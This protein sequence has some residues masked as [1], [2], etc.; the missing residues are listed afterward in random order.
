MI[1]KKKKS[2]RQ[3]HL[4]HLPSWTYLTKLVPINWEF[5]TA[6]NIS[7]KHTRKHDSLTFTHTH[8]HTHA[9]T[10]I[11]KNIVNIRSYSEQ[12][13]ILWT[14]K[15]KKSTH[16]NLHTWLVFTGTYTHIV[17]KQTKEINTYIL[18]APNNCSMNIHRILILW[19]HTSLINTH[20][21]I[22]TNIHTNTLTHTN[23]YAHT[24]FVSGFVP[25]RVVTSTFTSS[26]PT[27]KLFY[28]TSTHFCPGT[29][30]VCMY[31]YLC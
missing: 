12:T 20:K 8:K 21:S 17:N 13:L 24:L 4:L 1:P 5:S 3:F 30:H 19:T 26:Q 7:Y 29:Y 16:T 15:L 31:V 25:V 18:T 22:N 23:M 10:S 9:Q 14:S 28:S 2:K 11:H 27:T 6:L